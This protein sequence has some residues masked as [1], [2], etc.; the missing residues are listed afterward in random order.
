MASSINLIGS[1]ILE[2]KLGGA[3][4]F[5]DAE[6]LTILLCQVGPSI[7]FEILLP[8]LHQDAAN[9]PEDSRPTRPQLKVRLQ[10]LEVEDLE[11]RDFNYQNVIHSLRLSAIAQERFASGKVEERI[12]VEF[13]SVF[14]AT[15]SFTCRSGKVV[16]LEETRLQTGDPFANP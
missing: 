5:H 8:Q 6:I 9:S 3:P 15:C 14:G 10:F 12:R 2:E 7:S 13:D 16:G 4:S 1:E 11:L